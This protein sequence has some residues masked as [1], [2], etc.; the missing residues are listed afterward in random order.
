MQFASACAD[1]IDLGRDVRG[2]RKDEARLDRDVP[3]S[4]KDVRGSRK[5]VRGSR[6]DVRGSRKDEARLDRDVRGSRK[7]EAR[8][9]RDVRGSRK[10]V[11]GLRRD[12]APPPGDQPGL[13]LVDPRLEV[14][15]QQGRPGEPELLR[16]CG[17]VAVVMVDDELDGGLHDLIQ[18]LA[19]R[20]HV[21]RRVGRGR[22]L[23]AGSEGLEAQLGRGLGARQKWTR[24]ACGEWTRRGSGVGLGAHFATR[25]RARD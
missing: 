11:E 23:A 9:D 25:A 13:E 20:V 16:R 6:K 22:R 17:A 15:A 7:D 2:S 8:L 5:D 1:C 21:A 12:E 14:P 18:R 10:D 3:G 19:Q 24:S 4:R